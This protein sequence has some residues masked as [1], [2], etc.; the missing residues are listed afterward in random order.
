MAFPS[1]ELLQDASFSPITRSKLTQGLRDTGVVEGGTLMVHVRLS[2]FGWVVGGIDTVVH[3]LRDAVGPDGTLM[4]FCGWDD[5]PYHVD[6]WPER[7]QTAYAEMPAFD[8]ETSSSRRDFGRFPERLRT[9]PG[10]LRSTHPE[11]SFA[12]IG[13]QASSLLAASDEQDPWGK[14][15]P[16]GRLVAAKGQALLL[17]APLDKLTLSH[18]AEAIAD[19]PGKRRRTYQ[20]PTQTGLREF[21]T[22]DTFY[23]VLPY[24]EELPVGQL[25]RRA[26]EA[27]AGTRSMIGRAETHLFAAE[28]T[29]DAIVEHLEERWPHRVRANPVARGGGG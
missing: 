3:A 23:G 10:A 25:A 16:L 29:V 27:G 17:G 1:A 24:S 2:A 11:V 9:W 5:S 4:A 6:L 19:V 28:P 7:W 15:G 26:L 8:P 20:M 12:A 14:D 18:H 21:T 22:I 13:P